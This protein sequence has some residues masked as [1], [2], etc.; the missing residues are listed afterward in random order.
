MEV[1]GPLQSSINNAGVEISRIS[2]LTS[3]R[4]GKQLLDGGGAAAELEV[5]AKRTACEAIDADVALTRGVNTILSK[6]EE[7]ARLC[8]DAAGK[9]PQGNAA[10]SG[11]GPLAAKYKERAAIY[12]QV[13]SLLASAAP[14]APAM[15]SEEQYAA[16][17][18]LPVRTAKAQLG[19]GPPV[20]EDRN[21][22]HAASKGGQL[23]RSIWCIDPEDD[24]RNG[25]FRRTSTGDV[26]NNGAPQ[27]ELGS[28]VW[29]MAEDEWDYFHFPAIFL[30]S[31]GETTG[32]GVPRHPSLVAKAAALPAAETP[33]LD[34]I[35]T[36]HLEAVT[37]SEIVELLQ[38]ATEESPWVLERFYSEYSNA[39]GFE[40]SEWQ[41]EMRIPGTVVRGVRYNMPLPKDVPAAVAR[42][43]SIPEAT[44]VTTVLR[45]RVQ[46]DEA[47]LLLQTI[48][49]DAPFGENFRTQETLSFKPH[50]R[51]GVQLVKWGEVVW[52]Q[53]LSWTMGPVSK[54]IETKA[55]DGMRASVDTLV[56]LLQSKGAS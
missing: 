26:N 7:A 48:A 6:Y 23:L 16:K 55:T 36:F 20:G 34:P 38:P 15:S 35:A 30:G 28:K 40:A 27:S 3:L 31:P 21:T 42:L 19:I 54:I 53:A 9:K 52:V 8:L 5:L 47:I 37:V 46:G 10:A 4:A 1:L 17:V 50:E 56:R 14:P 13:C 49:H 32:G 41:E 33:N 12:R 39:S 51:G 22:G 18:L 2:G 29:P 24:A 44:R 45:L 43:V 25:G 11:L